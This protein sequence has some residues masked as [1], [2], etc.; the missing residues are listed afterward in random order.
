VIF[1]NEVCSTLTMMSSSN[2]L[3]DYVCYEKEGLMYTQVNTVLA[4]CA[5]PHAVMMHISCSTAIVKCDVMA[6]GQEAKYLPAIHT[7]VNVILN[8][9]THEEI[10]H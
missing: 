3:S 8:S 6:N 5:G 9:E 7:Q 1:S 10:C 4:Y 2:L